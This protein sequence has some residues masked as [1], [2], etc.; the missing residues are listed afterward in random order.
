MRVADHLEDS[1]SYGPES[2][3]S[4]HNSLGAKP[5]DGKA[6]ARSR[7]AAGGAQSAA[8]WYIANK[9][10]P[11][12]PSEA[13]TPPVIID[14][15][16]I[17]EQRNVRF[18]RRRQSAQWVRDRALIDA[19]QLPLGLRPEIDGYR[20]MK[21]ADSEWVRPPRL[22]RCSWSVSPEI[23]LH[24]EEGTAAY[25]SGVESCGS[26]WA[27]PV[28]AAVIRSERATEIQ[29]AV[30][31]HQLEGHAIVFLTLTL[32]HSAKD[33]LATNL[34]A[35]IGGWNRLL[36]GKAWAKFKD[37]FGVMGYI[38]SVEVTHSRKNG[39]HPHIHALLFIEAPLTPA[40]QKVFGDEIYGRWNRYVQDRGAK[41]PN[42]KRGVD[43]QQVDGSGKVVAQYLGKLQDDNAKKKN[44]SQWHAGKELA[45][46]DVKSGHDTSMSPF[47][48]L[49]SYARRDDDD[50]EAAKTLWLEYVAATTRRRAITWSRGLKKLYGVA[51]RDDDDVVSDALDKVQRLYVTSSDAYERLRRKNPALLTAALQALESANWGL[52]HHLLPPEDA[53][54]EDAPTFV[55]LPEPTYLPPA[56]A[57]SNVMSLETMESLQLPF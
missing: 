24:W 30:H 20:A 25:F 7:G 32:R 36:Q 26:I 34:E 39:W 51:E 16:A 31:R 11:P 41:S 18:A 47:E 22:A 27:C 8:A 4:G 45:R 29:T 56:P 6:L 43:V 50:D 46:G 28:C 5:R 3:L 21:A 17:S 53:G 49:D 1:T 2:P 55:P 37:R 10:T 13:P 38:R 12:S 19:G 33:S 14:H 15:E 9:V 40:Q 44:P 54:V 35:I 42:R 52:L 48:F 57:G 23:G